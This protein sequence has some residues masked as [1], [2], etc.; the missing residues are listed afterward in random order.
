MSWLAT[1]KGP[2]QLLMTYADKLFYGGFKTAPRPDYI[3]PRE[4]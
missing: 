1:V 2:H 3:D 4:H